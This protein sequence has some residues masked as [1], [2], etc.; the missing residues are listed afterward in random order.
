MF[1]NIGK[2]YSCSV[3]QHQD[4]FDHYDLILKF[5]T[6]QLKI[7]LEHSDS[8]FEFESKEFL[9][10]KWYRGISIPER[11]VKNSKNG[12]FDCYFKT[13]KSHKTAFLLTRKLINSINIK[14]TEY[15]YDNIT[16]H[17]NYKQTFLEIPFTNLN[18]SFKVGDT[19]KLVHLIF[20]NLTK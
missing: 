6:N 16:T 10:T 19:E 3:E 12:C 15:I 4:K 17:N 1:T 11:K 8:N 9:E 18:N 14:P 13:S 2:L 7:E 5:N 20:K